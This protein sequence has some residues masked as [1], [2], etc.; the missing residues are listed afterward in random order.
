[1][2]HSECYYSHGLCQFAVDYSLSSPVPAVLHPWAVTSAEPPSHSALWRKDLPIPALILKRYPMRLNTGKNS[3][4]GCLLGSEI[5]AKLG[6]DL[7]LRC[8]GMAVAML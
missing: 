5:F 7:M 8:C 1:M 4:Y 2:D 3:E 6:A